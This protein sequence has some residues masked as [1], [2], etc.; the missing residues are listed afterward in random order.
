MMVSSLCTYQDSQSH[1]MLNMLWESMYHGHAH[2]VPVDLFR[3]ILVYRTAVRP[4]DP[5]FVFDARG[6][7]VGQGG[8]RGHG[9]D[10]VIVGLEGAADGT[11]SG[12]PDVHPSVVAA[13]KIGQTNVLLAHCYL[14]IVAAAPLD[15]QTMQVV[16]A[17]IAW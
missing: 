7:Q 4:P 6:R 12:V 10:D 15:L 3:Q 8:V 14:S 2:L 13:C 11:R 9:I 17:A 5:H 1:P 16:S